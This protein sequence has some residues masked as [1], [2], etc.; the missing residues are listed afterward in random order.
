VQ[1]TRKSVEK[2]IEE[3]RKSS[4]VIEKL[5]ERTQEEVMADERG[6]TLVNRD[7]TRNLD[8]RFKL[9][10]NKE[11]RVNRE[12]QQ[13]EQEKAEKQ[14]VRTWVKDKVT[15]PWQTIRE[16]DLVDSVTVGEARDQDEGKVRPVEADA[17]RQDQAEPATRRSMTIRAEKPVLEERTKIVFDSE[18][19]RETVVSD[20]QAK[21]EK[22]QVLRPSDTGPQVRVDSNGVIRV[23]ST[24]DPN[25]LFENLAESA[26][27]TGLDE[28]GN[29]SLI[30]SEY[31]GLKQTDQE[32][33]RFDKAVAG[34][35]EKED[36]LP[37][38]ARQLV[39]LDA[40]GKVTRRVVAENGTR[41]ADLRNTDL[42]APS[43]IE[44]LE[45]GDLI[46]STEAGQVNAVIKSQLSNRALY[47]L[48][49]EASAGK[50]PRVNEQGGILAGELSK[51]RD[52][53]SLRG[54]VINSVVTSTSDAS[55]IEGEVISSLIDRE[56][57][58]LEAG[59]VVFG[60][61]SWKLE[62][63][64]SI[65]AE[66]IRAEDRKTPEVSGEIERL[67]HKSA[68]QKWWDSLRSKPG[69][70][71]KLAGGLH[72]ILFGPQRSLRQLFS[73]LVR[74]LYGLKALDYNPSLK[75]LKKLKEYPV[76]SS[77]VPNGPHGL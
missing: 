27:Q 29:R 41:F 16:G 38:G 37:A 28:T 52:F 71:G 5:V 21:A 72:F 9:F 70:V 33:R 3:R 25:A 23:P 44:S 50:P 8:T 58:E 46:W 51:I 13:M 17:R 1:N 32:K 35:R 22:D 26:E 76:N 6:E 43:G 45:S 18:V 57:F 19:T 75:Q 24:S 48:H 30:V 73:S 11:R 59:Q 10:L 64:Q 12:K 47:H 40:S 60:A 14:K 67:K 66:T 36:E 2:T 31:A 62:A 49:R 20:D 63:D 55:L 15:R 74:R 42:N 39:V 65:P 53:E 68:L 34:I 61:N 4:Y 69:W 56:S 77:A 54:V 7:F